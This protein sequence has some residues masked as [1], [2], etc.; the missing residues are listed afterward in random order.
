MK[1]IRKGFG[2]VLFISLYLTQLLVITT[3]Q[4]IFKEKINKF[5]YIL[6]LILILIIVVLIISSL[7]IS[8]LLYCSVY[9]IIGLYMGYLLYAFQMSI[10]IRLINH[11]FPLPFIINFFIQYIIPLIISIY[12]FINAR[13]TYVENIILK[14]PGFKGKIKILHLSDIHLGAIHQKNSIIRIV[15]EIRQ[16]DPDVVVITGDMADG[17]LQV[18]TE[19]LQPF[20]N[21]NIPIL[22]ITGNHEELNP[23]KEMIDAVQ[24]TKIKYIGQH[25]TFKYKGVNFIGEDYGY[26]L[27]KCLVNVKQ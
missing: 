5:C 3:N 14:Y 20:D 1:K 8:E 12:G 9:Y 2:L 18:K 25:G 17:S 6:P 24:K 21:L 13:L 27:R 16:L 22:F 15:Q 10:L 26:D 4:F 11:F 7:I 19:W 23:K